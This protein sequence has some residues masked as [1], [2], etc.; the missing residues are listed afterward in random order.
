MYIWLF[1]EIKAWFSLEGKAWA[2]DGADVGGSICGQESTA[3]ESHFAPKNLI[4]GYS[5]ICSLGQGLYIAFNLHNEWSK[6]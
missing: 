4:P 5:P 6:K 3:R 1:F 2:R